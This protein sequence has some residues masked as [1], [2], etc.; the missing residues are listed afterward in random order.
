VKAQ[1]EL[2]QDYARVVL[3]GAPALGEWLSDALETVR[4]DGETRVVLLDATGGV[5]ADWRLAQGELDALALFELPVVFAFEGALARAAAEV[6]LAADIRICGQSSSLQGPLRNTRR[7]LTLAGEAGAL[8][9]V[10]GQV[11]PAGE[12]LGSGLVS[13]V[14]P[15]GA[16]LTEAQRLAALI[17]SRGPYSTRLGKEAIW[18]GLP[19]ALDQALRFETDLTLLLQT[20]KDRAEGVRAF[21]EKRTPNFTGD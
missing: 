20:T 11:V 9:L 7:V 10:S 14:H 4:G 2:Q 1:I 6:A 3:A 16:V 21:L 15:A 18:R 13:S 17:A 5:P 12:L 19:L 8:P